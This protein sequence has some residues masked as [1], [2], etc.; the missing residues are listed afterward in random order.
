MLLYAVQEDDTGC[1]VPPLS[2]L[3]LETGSLS[4]SPQLST[5]AARLAA[6]QDLGNPSWA[7]LGL[8]VDMATLGLYVGTE[9]LNS[10]SHDYI[11]STLT[12][13]VI[14]L[15]PNSRFLSLL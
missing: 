7:V 15:V 13:Q 14:S 8:Q 12:Y 10:H 4:L 1:P 11:A 5:F 6:W 3:F 9:D 2:T